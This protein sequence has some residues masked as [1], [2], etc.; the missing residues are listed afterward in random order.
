MPKTWNEKDERNYEHIK[1]GEK[2][3]GRTMKRAKEIAARTVNKQ[4]R[5][6]GRTESS[7]TQG[8][9]NPNKGLDARTK[10]ELVNRAQ[11]LGLHGYS[12]LNKRELVQAIQ[13]D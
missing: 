5:A 1:R 4:R 10:Q 2:E 12:R 7:R 13:S 3:R 6:E 9:G 8:T 11:E